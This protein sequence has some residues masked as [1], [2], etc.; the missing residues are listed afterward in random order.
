MRC[1]TLRFSPPAIPYLDLFPQYSLTNLVVTDIHVPQCTFTYTSCRIPGS[2]PVLSQL[3]RLYA[4][5]ECVHCMGE[6]GC[7]YAGKKLTKC[8]IG[9]LWV[10]AF[11]TSLPYR[12]PE[13][14]IVVGRSASMVPR[15]SLQAEDWFSDQGRFRTHKRWYARHLGGAICRFCSHSSGNLPI[16]KSTATRK[17]IFKVFLG[18]RAWVAMCCS[19]NLAYRSEE[20]LSA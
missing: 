14:S 8:A 15:H 20:L 6:S 18:S 12:T 9:R 10:S 11:G 16:V 5:L 3:K 1:I 17:R 19:P 2:S 4:L 7:V 13:S